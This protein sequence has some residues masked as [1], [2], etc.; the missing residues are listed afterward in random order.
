MNKKIEDS[1]KIVS[2]KLSTIDREV[3]QAL[4]QAPNH[5][6][7]ALELKNTIGLKAVVQ[8]N[9][10]MGRIGRLLHDEM[11]S[12]PDGLMLNAFEWWHVISTGSKTN[13]RGFVWQLRTEVVAGL[14]ASGYS[15]IAELP[16]QAINNIAPQFW[17][18]HWQQSFWNP[19]S[20]VDGAPIQG[21][22][23]SVFGQRGVA[24]GDVIYI[25]SLA[26]GH[27]FLGGKMQITEIVSRDEAAEILG[28][29]NLYDAN[30]WAISKTGGTSLHLRRRLAPSLTKKLLF[31]RADGTRGLTFID[32][33]NLDN[34]ATRGLGKLTPDSARLLDSI[35]KATDLMPRADSL[36]TVTESML[37]VSP[38]DA[39]QIED[40]QSDSQNDHDL[41]MFEGQLK[42]VT[43]T[44]A[45]RSSKARSACISKHGYN[46]AACNMNFEQTYGLIGKDFI[47]IHHIEPLGFSNGL[48]QVNPLTDLIPVCP[49]CH[50]MVHRTNPPMSVDELRALINSRQS[51]RN[52]Y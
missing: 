47:H 14:L 24:V 5:S 1:V 26:A 48:H 4:L 46:C 19:K 52:N 34:Q 7:S 27:L 17:T 41:L 20:N 36:L 12:H 15:A 2:S 28:S 16:L 44:Q 32:Q 21:A 40:V 18:T 29:E 6:A 10:S 22:G 37:D 49:N 11:G 45:D 30:L 8:V 13:D 31:E 50:A 39:T 38:R 35:I 25:I 51:T 23:S 33:D 43:L 3:L 9:A 42:T